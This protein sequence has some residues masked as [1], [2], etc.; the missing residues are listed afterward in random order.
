MTPYELAIAQKVFIQKEE[1]RAKENVTIAWLS[2]YY[3]RQKKL[4]PLYEALGEEKPKQKVMTDEEMMQ[5][6]FKLN[7]KMGGEIKN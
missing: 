5:A 3:H 6:V 1:R 2:E 4:P 7:A